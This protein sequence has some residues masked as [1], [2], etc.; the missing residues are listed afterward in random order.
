MSATLT[1]FRDAGEF[2]RTAADF[3]KSAPAATS[4][5]AMPA[6][7]M[8]RAPNDDDAG[9]YLATVTNDGSVV[10]AVCHGNSGG[11][12]LSTAPDAA[13]LLIARDMAARGRRPDSV[14]APLRECGIFA[15]AWRDSTGA[16]PS[17]R[18]QLRH[19][20]LTSMPAAGESAGRLR[21]PHADEHALIASWHLAFIEDTGIPDDPERVL[22]HLERRIS[23]GLIRVWDVAVT[24]AA[25][26][27]RELVCFAGFSVDHDTAR[28]APVYTPP[29]LRGRGYATA[30][31]AE[32]A[33]ELFAAGKHAIHLTTDVANPTSNGIYQR[34]GFRPVVDHFHFDFAYPPA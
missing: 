2:L 13:V 29:A 28:I 3:L 33:R 12:L 23:R 18:F 24:G 15:R 14:V 4:M 19:F 5:I 25:R 27:V 34:I 7:R 30:M 1:V 16:S 8:L 11:A 21:A 31:V 22:R 32:L 26:D 17:Q 20:E 10:A 6:A 9:I